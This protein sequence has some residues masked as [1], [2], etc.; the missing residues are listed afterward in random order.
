MA[1]D[2]YLEL[3]A[4]E[5]QHR[6]VF[7]TTSGWLLSRRFGSGWPSRVGIFDPEEAL[8]VLG[9]YLRARSQLGAALL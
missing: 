6:D 8:A 1:K 7:V 3:Q 4:H 2:L 9:L 5:S